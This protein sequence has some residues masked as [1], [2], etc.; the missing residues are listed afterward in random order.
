MITVEKVNLGLI[1][2]SLVFRV[3]QSM[4]REVDDIVTDPKYEF[5]NK[6]DGCGLISA[7]LLEKVT[8]CG[9]PQNFQAVSCEIFGNYPVSGIQFRF[10]GKYKGVLLR[11]SSTKNAIT[12]RKSQKKA[13]HTLKVKHLELK[14]R[15]Q[16]RLL[17]FN[18]PL[19]TILL[20]PRRCLKH[21]NFSWK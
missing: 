15:I 7:N 14:E 18:S 1:C 8:C 20:T 4:I 21:V 5:T 16:A 9:A 11:D 13:D 17:K 3:E 12:F 19:L 6:T 10:G 2:K